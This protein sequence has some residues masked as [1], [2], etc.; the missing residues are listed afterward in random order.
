V[1]G[2]VTFNDLKADPGRAGLDSVLTEIPKLQC[3]DRLQLPANLFAVALAKQL[4]PYWQRAVSEPPS[5]APGNPRRAQ[6]R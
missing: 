5:V 2:K 4:A 1:S 6:R 3:I